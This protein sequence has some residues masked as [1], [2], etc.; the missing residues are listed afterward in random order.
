MNF[1]KQLGKEQTNYVMNK[2]PDGNYWWLRITGLTA[3]T[4][5]AFQYLVDGSLKVGDPYSDKV[6]DPWNDSFITTA[7]Y[8]NLKAYPTGLPT[9]IVS[10][11]QTNAP[12][13]NWAMPNF[14]RPDN[15]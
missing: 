5:Y 10:I 4:E 7:T 9:G 1:P 12:A 15:T 8:P 2:T 14:S 3:G 11:L 6:L 13:Y